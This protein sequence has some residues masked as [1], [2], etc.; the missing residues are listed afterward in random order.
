MQE[1]PSAWVEEA[2]RALRSCG[3]WGARWWHFGP[4]CNTFRMVVGDPV[5]SNIAI[6]L[7]N[8]GYLAGPTAWDQQQIEIQWNSNSSKNW[9]DW[10]F[11]LEDKRIG[12]RAISVT[13]HWAKNVQILD[14]RSWL[15][16]RQA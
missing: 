15:L 16:W 11:V 3:D 5:G 8:T 1:S 10:E 6:M 13:L 14:E 7:T 9:Q 4:P 12:F 2:N